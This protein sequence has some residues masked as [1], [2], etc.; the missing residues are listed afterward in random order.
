MMEER[1]KALEELD[2]DAVKIIDKHIKK[3]HNTE[4]K[5]YIHQFID[6][7]LDLRDKFLGIN[8]LKKPY[9]PITYYFNNKDGNASIIIIDLKQQ[10]ISTNMKLGRKLGILLTS[11]DQK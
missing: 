2:F 8:K 4:R 5:E 11:Q 1:D 6:K 3:Q 7:D 10:R 9:K